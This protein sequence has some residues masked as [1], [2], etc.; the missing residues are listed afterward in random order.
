MNRIFL[1]IITLLL[2]GCQGTAIGSKLKFISSGPDEFMILTN[3][4]LKIPDDFELITPTNELATINSSCNNK[5]DNTNCDLTKAE[6]KLLN[7]FSNLNKTNT[8]KQS[9]NPSTHLLE[10]SDSKKHGSHA[11]DCTIDAKADKN[12]RSYLNKS[13]N[14][15]ANQDQLIKSKKICDIKNGSTHQCED[16][17]IIKDFPLILDQ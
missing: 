16:F 2:A 6:Q 10:F 11:K 3:K 1:I 4:P 5:V 7:K 12:N 9:V 15:S 17:K 8:S 13:F 14:S